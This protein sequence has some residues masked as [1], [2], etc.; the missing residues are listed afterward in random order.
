MKQNL[1]LI[2]MPGAG[3]STVGVLLAKTMGKDFVDTDLLIQNSRGC[4]LPELIRAEGVAG[5]LAAEEQVILGLRS[6]NAVLATG[7]S[8][9]YSALAMA[10][11]KSLG[12]VV[13]LKLPLSVIEK[14]ID[15][16]ASRGIAMAAGQSLNDL[17]RE[18]TP[19]YENY[20]DV[21]VDSSVLS[22]EE[23]VSAIA[24]AVQGFK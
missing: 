21:V 5:F 10:H 13:Y 15:N 9:V 6:E 11:L 24:R 22:L 4:L 2:G 19:L 14:R 16:M 8:V 17:Y 12:P 3:K 7:G 18:R 23:T 1:V 20:A